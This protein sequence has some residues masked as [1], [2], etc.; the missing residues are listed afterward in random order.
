MKKHVIKIGIECI[1][2][3]YTG[4]HACCNLHARRRRV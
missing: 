1:R 3:G 4:K 2:T